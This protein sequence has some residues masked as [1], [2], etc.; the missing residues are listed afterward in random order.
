MSFGVGAEERIDMDRV[1]ELAVEH[2]PKL[3]VAGTTS[4]PR[5]LDPGLTKIAD[6]GALL[7]FD[8][9]HLAGLVAGGAHQTRFLR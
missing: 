3:I 6:G 7:L 2:R 4:Y 9:A 5:R 8:A 1:R